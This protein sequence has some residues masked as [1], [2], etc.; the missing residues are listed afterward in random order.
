MVATA[1]RPHNLITLLAIVVKIGW[2]SISYEVSMLL[3]L[4]SSVADVY[5]GAL[6]EEVRTLGSIAEDEDA[7]DG[8][9]SHLVE[10][11]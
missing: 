5:L 3:N 4:G 10:V 7:H 2:L 9:G 8:V 11:T 6:L 1:L